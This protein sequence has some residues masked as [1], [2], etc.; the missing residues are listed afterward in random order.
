MTPEETENFKKLEKSIADLSED[1]KKSKVLLEQSLK[2]NEALKKDNSELTKV[3]SSLFLQVGL[4]K[5]EDDGKPIEDPQ[6]FFDKNK[7]KYEKYVVDEK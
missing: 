3:N 7:T 2:D 5:P 4:K 6:E 1:S